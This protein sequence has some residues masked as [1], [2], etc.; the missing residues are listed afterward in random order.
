MGHQP[1]EWNTGLKSIY[2]QTDAVQEGTS[3]VK[4][5]NIPLIHLTVILIV[6]MLLHRPEWE[7][8]KIWKDDLN[9]V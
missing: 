2:F 3:S 5:I 7:F 1:Q 8:K 6:L 9:L 4:P